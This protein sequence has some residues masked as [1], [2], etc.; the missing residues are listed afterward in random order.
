VRGRAMSTAPAEEPQ[1]LVVVGDCLLDQD[2]DGRAERLASD[3]P[4]PVLTG[5]RAQHRPGGAGLA[6]CVAAAEGLSVRL[7]TALCRDAGGEQLRALLGEAG[8]E[9]LDLGWAGTTPEKIRIR[10]AGQTLLRLDGGTRRSR[11]PGL[12]AAEV[13]RALATASAVVVSDYGYGVTDQA[14]LRGAIEEY[15]QSGPV[16]WDPHPRSRAPIPGAHLVKPNRREAGGGDDLAAVAH[17]ARELR[18]RWQ[19]R[20]VAVTLGAD[21]A[22]LVTDDDVPPL[23]APA[24]AVGPHDSCGAGDRFTVA[25]ARAIIEG[26]SLEEAVGRAV[27]AASRFVAAGGAAVVGRDEDGERPASSSHGGVSAA[28]QLATDVHARGGRLVAT[29]GCFDLLH[30]GHVQMLEAARRLGDGLVVL[31]NSDRSVRGLKGPGR[32]M[33][34][35]CDRARVLSALSCVD[36]VAIFDEPTPVPI[37]EQLRPD[38]FAKGADYAERR[39]PEQEAVSGWNGQVVVLPYLE[40]HSTTRLIQEVARHG[41][42]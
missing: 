35:A 18:G 15:A 34:A 32:P 31:L 42:C 1:H 19:A 30:A 2:V 8:V 9:V 7:I 33:L 16:V 27:D 5:P 11:T 23:V 24:P 17:R 20:G 6:A 41:A 37:L 14:R 12:P 22:L 26:S 13:L 38:V 29:S 3:A 28:F 21:G 39:L 40:G 36:A 10:S 4:V 25:A